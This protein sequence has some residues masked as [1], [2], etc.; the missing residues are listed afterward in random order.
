MKRPL[1]ALAFLAAVTLPICLS[2]TLGD[3]E[4][5]KLGY[6]TRRKSVRYDT[7]LKSSSSSKKKTITVAPKPKPKTFVI[8]I[9]GFPVTNDEF[10]N[11]CFR[12][13]YGKNTLTIADFRTSASADKQ[14]FAESLTRK[15][16]VVTKD[17]ASYHPY[18]A[19]RWS[20]PGETAT[21]TYDPIKKKYTLPEPFYLK[22]QVVEKAAA[23]GTAL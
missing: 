9:D 7:P 19:H 15:S 18:D 2:L 22:R 14:H 1:F 10:F 23:S 17:C 21:F 12:A 20:I 11:K 5:G 4:A 8:D 6:S 13:S 16:E 3:Q